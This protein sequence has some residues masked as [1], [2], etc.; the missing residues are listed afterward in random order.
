MVSKISQRAESREPAA[1]LNRSMKFISC[2]RSILAGTIL[3]ASVLHAEERVIVNW[4]EQPAGPLSPSAM[5]DIYFQILEA[6][7]AQV[8]DSTTDPKVPFEKGGSAL[9]IK[10]HDGKGSVS[11]VLPFTDSPRKGWIEF[12]AVLQGGM[13]VLNF[14]ANVDLGEGQRQNGHTGTNFFKMFI[15]PNDNSVGGMLNSTTGAD[16]GFRTEPK[17]EDEIPHTFRF[18]WDFEASSPQFQM[19]QNGEIMTIKDSNTD[20]LP[21]DPQVAAGGVNRVI[22]QILG[23][24]V[25]NITTSP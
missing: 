14:V 17:T 24:V 21:V 6:P 19:L 18:V 16:D 7:E 12:P 10:Q 2:L 25:G 3:C 8:I 13:L 5:P 4:S 20:W 11:L 9:F 15:R 1:G 22:I 23:G